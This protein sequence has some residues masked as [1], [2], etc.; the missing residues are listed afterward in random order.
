MESEENA[1]P[2]GTK[3]ASRLAFLR[4][5]FGAVGAEPVVERLQTYAESLCRAA[6]V[7]AAVLQRAEDDLLL[8]ISKR[9]ADPHAHRV[10]LGDRLFHARGEM[11]VGQFHRFLGK[12]EGAVD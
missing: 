3:R 6:L 1:A 7:A 10:P 5:V 9:R 11:R 8:R 2:A 12:D 4:R